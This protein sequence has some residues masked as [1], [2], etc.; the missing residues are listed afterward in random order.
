MPRALGPSSGP[1]AT[2]PRPFRASSPGHAQA[3]DH[4]GGWLEARG[5]RTG[6]AGAQGRRPGPGARA[7][8]R[9][10]RKRLSTKAT[11]TSPGGPRPGP[12]AQA[13]GPGRPTDFLQAQAL[14]AF[15]SIQTDFPRTRAGGFGQRPGSGLGSRTQSPGSGDPGVPKGFVVF[16]S[17]RY[18]H[19]GLPGGAAGAQ[20]PGAW[21]QGPR[22][23]ART[24]GPGLGTQGPGPGA[25]RTGARARGPEPGA[26][27]RSGDAH[28]AS[29]W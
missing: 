14:S 6:A 3:K 4:A 9:C 29:L 17:A 27:D 16:G 19:R 5:P 11:G 22:P 23:V 18:A 28:S 25:R 2:G 20:W 12:R 1:W 26:R 8:S 13:L 7:C 10:Q 15:S 21:G 24:R